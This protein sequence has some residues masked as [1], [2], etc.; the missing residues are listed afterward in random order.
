VGSG[1]RDAL[2]MGDVRV[3]SL[4]ASRDIYE[5]KGVWKEKKIKIYALHY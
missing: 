1:F 4:F 3:H 2:L 5:E